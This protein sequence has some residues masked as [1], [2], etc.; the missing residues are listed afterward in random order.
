MDWLTF[1]T[2]MTESM[3]WPLALLIALFI[4]RRPLLDL[5]NSVRKLK[6]SDFEAEFEKNLAKIK[7]DSDPAPT[8]E[9]NDNQTISNRQNELIEMTE[10]GPNAAVL[11]AWQEL[12]YAANSLLESKGN[13]LNYT[14][15]SPYILMG[16]LLQ[17]TNL[18][19]SKDIKVFHELRN[20]RNKVAHAE[21]FEITRDQSREY[22]KLSMSL[23]N[24]LIQQLDPVTALASD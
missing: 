24:R 9:Q 4:V 12:E 2:K 1:T 6:I 17:E 19:N 20:L 14:H 5:L 3:A 13:P 11:A 18:L 8:P 15:G 23:A 10:F 22:V 7:A 16:K 21:G